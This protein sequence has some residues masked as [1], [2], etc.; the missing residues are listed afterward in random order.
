MELP[1]YKII[2]NKNNFDFDFGQGFS[3]HVQFKSRLMEMLMKR[4]IIPSQ[5]IKTKLNADMLECGVLYCLEFMIK[6]KE[7]KKVNGEWT[8]KPKVN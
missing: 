4:I 2:R 1:E 3:G 8:F 5:K 6:N 7:L